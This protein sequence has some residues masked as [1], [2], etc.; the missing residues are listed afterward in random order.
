MKSPLR[1]RVVSRAAK[2]IV[3]GAAWWSTNR[4]LA[5][6]AYVSDIENALELIASHPGVGAKARS[7]NYGDVR[8]LHLARIRFHLYYRVTSEP[9]IEVLA[10][11]HTS[12][13]TPPPI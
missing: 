7:K 12:R 3:D 5:P 10:L 11:W 8:R 4:P 2:A 13:G 9:A 1:V 6:D